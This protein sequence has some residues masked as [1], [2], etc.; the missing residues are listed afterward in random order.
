MISPQQQL[1]SQ[2]DVVYILHL[3]APGTAASL[4]PAANFHRDG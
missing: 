3:I 1:P 4:A 2:A